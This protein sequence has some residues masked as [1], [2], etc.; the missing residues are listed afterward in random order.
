MTAAVRI[1]SRV[2]TLQLPINTSTPRFENGSQ[3]A[4]IPSRTSGTST[5][6]FVEKPPRRRTPAHVQ[7]T[8]PDR[9]RKTV[10]LPCYK[11]PRRI[12][13]IGV[14]FNSAAVPGGEARAPAALRAAGLVEA[15]QRAAQIHD[16]GDIA[17]RRSSPERDPTSGIIAPI[18]LE[19]MVATVRSKVALALG[20]GDL[21]LA[22]GGDRP[23][24]LGCLAAARD[25]HER[26]GLFFVDGREDVWPPHQSPTGEAADRRSVLLSG[27]R[28]QPASR[29][30]QPS[31]R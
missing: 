28:R 26:V 25:A 24:L 1:H 18:S 20:Q 16:Y 21:P 19:E 9:E 11:K 8:T 23:V 2:S 17:L 3:P 4:C 31:S 22:I 12:G 30:W 27:W 13:L 29:I 6:E 5:P 14:P 7:D 15:L 10:S